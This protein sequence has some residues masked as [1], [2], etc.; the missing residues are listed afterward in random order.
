MDS[1][2]DGGCW[3]GNMWGRELIL[4]FLDPEWYDRV[5]LK[6]VKGSTGLVRIQ[7]FGG[8]EVPQICMICENDE[9]M[10]SILQP[11][12]PLLQPEL[13]SQ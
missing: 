8:A 11:V 4:A 5:K 10:G 2:P 1:E 12:S 7:T 3:W 6:W 9:Q 13:H